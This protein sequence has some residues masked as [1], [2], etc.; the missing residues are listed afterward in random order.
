MVRVI[1][2]VVVALLLAA[3]ASGIAHPLHTSFTEIR[4][5]RAG[6]ITMSI[7]LFADDF[8]ATLDS[9]RSNSGAPSAEF[10]AQQYLFRSVVLLTAGKAVPLTWCGMRSEGGLTWLCARSAKPVP[11]VPL[12]VRNGLMFDRFADQISIIRWDRGSAGQTRT[13]VLSARAP[14]GQLD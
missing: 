8:E 5:D 6:M 12:R 11:S 14:E 9:L 4:R 10:A 13:M 1:P 2:A 3:P 7:R